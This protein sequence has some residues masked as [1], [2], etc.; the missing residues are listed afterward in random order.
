ME[1][2]GR[3][4]A[5][6]SYCLDILHTSFIVSVT[7]FPL[8]SRA[9][10]SPVSLQSEQPVSSVRCPFPT[11][12]PGL[13]SSC[14]RWSP[15]DTGH[16]SSTL[17]LL[18]PHSLGSGGAVKRAKRNDSGIACPHCINLSLAFNL[19]KFRIQCLVTW[20]FLNTE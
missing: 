8:E 1:L 13:L 16:D 11:L 19:N 6:L 18:Q 15:L 9:G 12:H 10:G 7:P 17:P 20:I 5:I 2:W 14:L 3:V 4:L